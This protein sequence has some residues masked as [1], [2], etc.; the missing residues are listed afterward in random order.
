MPRRAPRSSFLRRLLLVVGVLV[1][2]GVG[3]VVGVF[4]WYSRGLPSVDAL[5]DYRPPQVTKV[6]CA[7]GNV[8]AEYFLERRTLVHATTLPA[9]VRNAFLAAEDADF[10]NTKGWTTWGWCAP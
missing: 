4:L 7:D 10:Y 1:L 3:T 5:R 9:H 2:A 8:C 6:T